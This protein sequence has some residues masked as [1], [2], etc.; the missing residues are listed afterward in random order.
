MGK[1][2]VTSGLAFEVADHKRSGSGVIERRA[3]VYADSA[4]QHEEAIVEVQRCANPHG[5][6]SVL[7]AKATSACVHISASRGTAQNVYL[8]EAFEQ[9]RYEQ[10][11]D[12]RVAVRINYQDTLLCLGEP[13]SQHYERVPLRTLRKEDLPCLGRLDDELSVAERPAGDVETLGQELHIQAVTAERRHRRLCRHQALFVG[14]SVVSVKNPRCKGSDSSRMGSGISLVEIGVEDKACRLGGPQQLIGIGVG[15]KH[16]Y[17]DAERIA[18]DFRSTH[19]QL[20]PFPGDLNRRR[21]DGIGTKGP[22]ATNGQGHR[23]PTETAQAGQG[24]AV[25]ADDGGSEG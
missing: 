21:R 20:F 3:Y 16:T 23:N 1:K 8:K 6:I 2:G 24:S 7:L 18:G 10:L 14:Q 12:S 15:A 17:Q 5:D 11:E 22:T 25:E 19:Q 4:V 13:V 9:R